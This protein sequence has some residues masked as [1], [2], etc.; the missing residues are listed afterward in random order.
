M[1]E[2]DNR[3]GKNIVEIIDRNR[4]I[5]FGTGLV[6]RFKRKDG[7]EKAYI[8]TAQ[9]VVEEQPVNVVDF[10]GSVHPL[11]FHNLQGRD[12]AI[13]KVP[14]AFP[15]LEGLL[16]AKKENTT[17]VYL[18]SKMKGNI[19][20]KEAKYKGGLLDHT[21]LIT[22]VGEH[23][24]GGGFSGSPILN[25]ENEVLGILIQGTD[26]YWTG[27][28]SSNYVTEGLFNHENKLSLK[29]KL[30]SK[31]NILRLVFGR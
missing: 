31:V 26:N 9:H 13:S 8:L 5:R 4:S 21:F 6:A 7:V 22:T 17:E 18:A 30:T 25:S 23:F 29:R 2:R 11:R 24:D 19:I 10:Q 16:V 15:K 28:P 12:L 14:K 20:I 1:L 3:L 27:V